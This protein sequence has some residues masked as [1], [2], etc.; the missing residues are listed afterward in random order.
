MA[1]VFA[2]PDTSFVE[3]GRVAVQT[4]SEPEICQG[5]EV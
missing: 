4:I 3:A 1:R 5:A 2:N